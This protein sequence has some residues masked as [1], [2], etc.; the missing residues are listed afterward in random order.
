M[1]VFIK[2]LVTDYGEI[3]AGLTAIISFLIFLYKKL[4]KPRI[5]QPITS[6]LDKIDKVC[7][8]LGPNGGKSF[9]DKISSIDRKIGITNSR[10]SALNSA[11]GLGEWLSDPEGNTIKVNDI[12]CRVTGRPE[13]DFMGQDWQNVV[14]P[15]DREIVIDDWENSVKYHRDFKMR[16]RW[17]NSNGAEII[18]DATARLIH[19]SNNKIVGYLG[20]VV[21]IDNEKGPN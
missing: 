6:R 7:E 18:I 4:I 9:Y 3:A 20:T 15:E 11:L 14:H 16:Y 2:Q 5:I 8:T 19:D 12:I 17:T 13:T 21:F 1:I 10:G